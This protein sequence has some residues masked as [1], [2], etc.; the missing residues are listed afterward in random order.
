MD[1]KLR[2]VT[3]LEFRGFFAFINFEN[4]EIVAQQL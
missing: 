4:Q 2:Y 3:K 1:I